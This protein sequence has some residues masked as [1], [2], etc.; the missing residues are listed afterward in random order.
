MGG[1]TAASSPAKMRVS[2]GSRWGSQVPSPDRSIL[3]SAPN[4]PLRPRAWSTEPNIPTIR[5]FTSVSAT[6]LGHTLEARMGDSV[7][8]DRLRL[9]MG[10]SNHFA[11]LREMSGTRSWE[12][13]THPEDPDG[14]DSPSDFLRHGNDIEPRSYLL[15]PPH[16]SPG[17]SWGRFHTVDEVI[18][19]PKP[20]PPIPAG[21]WKTMGH[22]GGKLSPYVP[23][24]DVYER[25]KREWRTPGPGEYGENGNPD[26]W[27]STCGPGMG[28]GPGGRISRS[29]RVTDADKISKAGS[30]I[31]GPGYYNTDH[32][33]GIYS[34]IRSCTPSLSAGQLAGLHTVTTD[35]ED[36]IFDQRL[37]MSRTVPIDSLMMLGTTRFSRL[38]KDLHSPKVRKIPRMPRPAS[39]SVMSTVPPED[40]LQDMDADFWG[41]DVDNGGVDDVEG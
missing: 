24:N 13:F 5:P 14:R 19:R 6:P 9:D 15:P 30:V 7:E 34:R 21:Q 39:R 35:L 23:I 38:N 17:T 3:R 10:R 22:H 12:G 37:V 16:G 31:P 27:I 26:P 2:G 40:E 8:D 1:A 28:Q 25:C 41:A 11:G 29:Q 18:S 36:C 32:L 4:Q 20:L 33:F